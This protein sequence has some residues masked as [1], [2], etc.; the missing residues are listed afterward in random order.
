MMAMA[1]SHLSLLHLHTLLQGCL[2]AL[3]H[4]Q[5]SLLL[6]VWAS[7]LGLVKAE[8]TLPAVIRNHTVGAFAT[9][10]PAFVFGNRLLGFTCQL[11]KQG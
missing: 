5:T 8:H 3:T 11:S 7:E 9:S 6:D 4:S 2:H 10:T 1:R